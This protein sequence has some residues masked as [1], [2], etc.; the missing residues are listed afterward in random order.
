M[1][2]LD[3]MIVGAIAVV[4]SLA[5]AQ[6]AMPRQSGD[7]ITAGGNG[8]IYVGT[9][10]R[11]ILVVDEAT[12]QVRDTIRSNVGIPELSLSFDRKHLYLSDPGNEKI[13]IVDL[14]TKKS[15][16]VFTLSTDSTT[17]RMWGFEEEGSLRGQ[18]ADPAPL[19]PREASSHGHHSVAQGRGAR[20][21]PSHLL[22]QGRLD[23]FLHERRRPHLRREHVQ[24]G[25][26][27]GDLANAV[28][29]RPRPHRV[30]LSV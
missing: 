8:T 21:R 2:I 23:V 18:P 11:N 28:R 1:R 4:G 20:I 14:A 13:E 17:V 5:S 9:Y 25:R 6:S 16:G 12:M 3:T 26:S 27:M 30:R 29:G 15:S 22:A 19:R 10:A 7:P 24:A